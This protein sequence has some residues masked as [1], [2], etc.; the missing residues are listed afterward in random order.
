[1]TAQK[2][3]G[4]FFFMLKNLP[5]GTKISISRSIA[6][7]F[8]KYMNQ[9]QWQEEQFDPAVFMQHWRQYI[10]KQVAWFHS[11]DEEIKQS[12][13]FHQE[14][15]AKINEIM[16]KVLSEKP[17]EEQLQ[18]IEQLTKELQIEDIPVSCKA[19]ANYYI[20]QLQ[21]KKKQRV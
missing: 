5:H 12:P 19:E 10:E 4:G 17:T 18:T 7:V 9:I 11:L 21:E 13:S 8:E 1:V 6:F 14:L 16:E 3:F 15:A 20:E 2:N